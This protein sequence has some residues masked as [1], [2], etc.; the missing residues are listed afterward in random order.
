MFVQ[1]PLSGLLFSK[2]KKNL[3]MT[4]FILGHGWT[5]LSSAQKTE[6]LQWL[7]GQVMLPNN[8]PLGNCVIFLN[9]KTTDIPLCLCYRFKEIWGTEH[10]TEALTPAQ[11]DIQNH[12][13]NGWRDH[14]LKWHKTPAGLFVNTKYL[15]KLCYNSLSHSHIQ[16]LALNCGDW[17]WQG[18]CGC[19]ATVVLYVQNTAGQC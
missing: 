17:L 4:G 16:A 6:T 19:Y 7:K 2:R 3:K 12:Q 18:T 8:S 1:L 5:T 11:D 14:I 9:L 13:H 15:M 10:T